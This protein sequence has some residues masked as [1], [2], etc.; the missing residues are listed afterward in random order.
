VGEG[1]VVVDGDVAIAVFAVALAD[2][3]VVTALKDGWVADD[4][5]DAAIGVRASTHPAVAGADVCD[6]VDLIPGA[7][8][9][10][11]LARAGND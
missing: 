4:L 8:M 1:D 6:D 9:E 10:A 7:R 3:D 5:L 11:D 2:S